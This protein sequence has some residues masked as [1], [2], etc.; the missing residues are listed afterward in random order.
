MSRFRFDL[1]TEADD[2]DLRDV[3]ARTPM[4]GTVAVTFRREPSYFRA[5]AVDGIFRQVIACRDTETGRVIGFGMRAVRPVYVNGEPAAV[6]YLGGLRGLPEYRN[7]GLLARGYAFLRQLHADGRT[8]FYL[9]TI[10]EGNDVALAV[11]TSGRAGL[12]TYHFAGLY[13]TAAVP[14]P[15]RRMGPACARGDVSIEAACAEDLPEVLAFL[16][17][18]GRRRQFFP[19]YRP[20][21]FFTLDGTLLDLEPG[22]LLLARR[23]GRLI[24]TLAGWDQHRFKQV[25]VNGYTGVL[26]WLRPVINLAARFTGAPRLP[27][28]GGELRYLTAALSLVA[29]DEP[30]VFAALLDRLR[31]QAAGRYDYL[32]VGLHEM[33]P[34]LAVVRACR[35]RW[36]TTR[37]YLVCWPDGE[38]ARQALTDRVP[39]LELGTL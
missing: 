5:A 19:C 9:T 34:L 16:H 15:R 24:G 37:L 33:D 20:E 8:P 22:Q 10:A 29:G 14:L 27:P 1:A 30:A 4:G 11:L 12:P 28:P 38:A 7:R 36:Y 6:G 17:T 23:G 2:A 39:Y 13:Q 26:R 25:I 32:L 31:H 3:L 35:A 21:D 18:E